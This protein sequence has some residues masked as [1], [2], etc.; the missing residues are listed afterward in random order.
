MKKVLKK[1]LGIVLIIL[2][3]LALL[4]PFSPGSWLALIGLEFLGIRLLVE[5]K[6]SSFL[7]ERHRNALLR[8]REKLRRLSPWAMLKRGDRKS[9]R[10]NKNRD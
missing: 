9:S 4:T 8:W 6:L 5:R 3:L 10:S 1:P 7:S 2:G